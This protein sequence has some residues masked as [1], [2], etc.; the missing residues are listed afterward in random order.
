LDHLGSI[1]STNKVQ[2]TF[3]LLVREAFGSEL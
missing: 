2:P 3:F 1:G